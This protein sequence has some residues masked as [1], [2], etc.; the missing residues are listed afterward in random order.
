LGGD[1]QNRG[2]SDED[3]TSEEEDVTSTKGCVAGKFGKGTSGQGS[4]AGGDSE[5]LKGYSMKKEKALKR[6]AKI[7]ALMSD[8]T[9]RYSSSSASTREA[10]Q[11]AKAAIAK[12]KTVVESQSS[13]GTAKK[14]QV[15]DSTPPSKATSE[16]SGPK[17]KRFAAGKKATAAKEMPELAAPKKTGA[18]KEAALKKAVVKTKMAHTKVAVTEMTAKKPVLA[19]TPK[20]PVKTRAKKSAPVSD[21][22]KAASE[23]AQPEIE[24][25]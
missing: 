12:A 9:E 7:E 23:S 14:A 11:D 21:H 22:P 20:A 17:A 19:R 3:G 18:R 2:T 1:P 5:S 4:E 24:A 8:L 16:P 6:L 15:R 13:S 25:H 10:L